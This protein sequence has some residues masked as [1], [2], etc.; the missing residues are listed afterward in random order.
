MLFHLRREAALS[1]AA[2]L[3]GK[4][5]YLPGKLGDFI[6]SNNKAAHDPQH[7]G[8]DM[9]RIGIKVAGVLHA[10]I[11]QEALPGTGVAPDA[12]WN[13]LAGL[14]RD[15]AP[16]NRDLLDLRDQLQS[17][18]DEYHRANA[19]KPFDAPGYE[20]FLREIGYLRPEPDDFSIRTENVDDEIARIAGPQ[21]VVPVSNARYALNAANAR[22]GSLYDA[23]YGTDAIP[24][25]GGAE[26]GRGFNTV[27][28]AR[29]IAGAP[30]NFW[31][32]R[33]RSTKAVTRTQPPTLLRTDGSSS[34]LRDGGRTGLKRPDQ[35][36]GYRGERRRP[37]SR[38]AP[39]QQSAHRDVDRPLEPDRAQDDPAGVADVIIESAVS[40]IMD[41]EDSVAAV[42]ADDK[43]EVYRN[44]LGLMNGT[45]SASSRRAAARSSAAS[46]PTAVY[47]APNGGKL[48]LPGR[49]LMLVRNVGH[50][51]YTDAV[52]DEAGHE[53]SRKACSMPP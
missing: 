11:E 36:V 27:R 25:D 6:R 18:I 28:G 35:F 8:Y 17:R 29:V 49:S 24:E 5:H 19:G 20:R 10:F 31:M 42:D 48:R 43:V 9:K 23:L 13:G 26:R 22:W 15:L 45:L 30:R 1:R 16:R 37:F 21:L 40:T 3:D 41:L 39:Q 46:A 33:R 32:R 2:A 12:F 44:W 34:R 47:T 53:T 52:L 38:A 51:M 50:H 4:L 14:V 7:E